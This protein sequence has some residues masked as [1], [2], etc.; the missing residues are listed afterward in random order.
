[1]DTQRRPGDPIL[2]SFNALPGTS[3]FTCQLFC[4]FDSSCAMF[5][6]S[7]G[8]PG[9]SFGGHSGFFEFHRVL[10]TTYRSKKVGSFSKLRHGHLVH[11]FFISFYEPSFLNTFMPA[12]I[13]KVHHKIC[14]HEDGKKKWGGGGAPLG[15]SIKS[16]HPLG[17]CEQGQDRD[18]KLKL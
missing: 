13:P 6:H 1:M 16:G 3:F 8:S 11:T 7:W 2:C 18:L 12:T 5:E 9:G 15:Q 10:T 17:P 14:I 4:C